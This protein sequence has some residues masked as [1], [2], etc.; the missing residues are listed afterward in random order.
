MSAS[1]QLST[2]FVKNTI[3]GSNILHHYKRTIYS[4]LIR[5]Y[6]WTIKSNGNMYTAAGY[7]HCG[8]ATFVH[9]CFH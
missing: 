4:S 2:G 3:S 7:L 9:I 8:I 5:L 1:P 6:T